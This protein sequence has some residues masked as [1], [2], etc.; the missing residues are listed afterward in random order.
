MMACLVAINSFT[1]Q[2]HRLVLKPLAGIKIVILVAVF[3]VSIFF[4]KYALVPLASS[5]AKMEKANI[6]ISHGR[7]ERAHILLDDASSADKLS[8]L[9]LSLNARLYLHHYRQ[10]PDKNP[11]LLVCAEKCLKIA[12]ERNSAD[13]KKYERLTEVYLLLSEQS[14]GRDKTDWLNKAFSAASSAVK[15]YP[16]CGRL[17][18]NIAQ[19][20]EKLDKT[21]IALNEYKKTIQIEGQYRDQF[22]QMYPEIKKIV[23]RLGEDKYRLAIERVRDL[24]SQ[25]EL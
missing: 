24:S 19:I 10:S 22:Q 23:S 20:A 16:G 11:E 7:F 18:F 13:F 2:Q 8:P 21:D 12:I 6:A 15:L 17:H 14:A 25:S 5:T 9:A 1:N 3:G 4:I